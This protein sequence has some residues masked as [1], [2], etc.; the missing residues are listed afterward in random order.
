MVA[1]LLCQLCA[2]SSINAD[3][4]LGSDY[5]DDPTI[6]ATQASFVCQVVI[7]TTDD[8]CFRGKTVV[9]CKLNLTAPATGLLSNFYCPS[10]APA[11]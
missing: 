10:L 1:Q 7:K 6:F 4:S 2:P 3:Q 8:S 9:K 5:D 11:F